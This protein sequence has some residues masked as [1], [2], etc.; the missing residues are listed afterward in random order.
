MAGDTAD[1]VPVLI[2]RQLFSGKADALED[3]YVIP[4]HTGFADHGTR[5]VVDR[6]IMSYLSS[7]MNV[8]T[9]FGM[10]HFGDHPGYKRNAQLIKLVR[11]TIIAYCP[12]A[13]VTEDNFI[14]VLCCRIAV[15]GGFGI[16]GKQTAHFRQCG[17]ERFGKFFC[18]AEDLLF[19]TGSTAGVGQ[20]KARIDLTAEQ[21]VQLFNIDPG[22]ETDRL[23][24]DPRIPVIARKQDCTAQVNDLL[25]YFT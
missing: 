2:G 23:C 14:D 13:R 6:E 8:D 3:A 7:R 16:G 9:G 15:V 18:L 20:A 17:N 22:M 5:T 4:D 1:R 19:R 21:L 24:T 11:Y 25:Q 12:E 10:S